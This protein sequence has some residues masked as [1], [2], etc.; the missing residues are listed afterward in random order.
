MSNHAERKRS[1]RSTQSTGPYRAVEHFDHLAKARVP[2]IVR[3][4]MLKKAGTFVKRFRTSALNATVSWSGLLWLWRYLHRHD[5]IVLMIHGTMDGDTPS[6]WKPLRD[7]LSPKHLDKVLRVL[8]QRYRFVSLDEAAAIVT[9]N[10]PS[11]RAL[12]VT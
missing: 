9:G 2:A 11:R 5:V 3:D 7:R 4:D 12:V 10:A 8:A 6:T 1:S